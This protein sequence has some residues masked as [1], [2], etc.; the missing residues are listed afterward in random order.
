MLQVNPELEREAKEQYAEQVRF[1]LDPYV[2]VVGYAFR[3]PARKDRVGLVCSWFSVQLC[4][5]QR[6]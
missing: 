6:K 2:Y 4:A 3:S 5:N 1:T